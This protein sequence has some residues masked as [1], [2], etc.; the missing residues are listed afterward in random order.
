MLPSKL[1]LDKENSFWACVRW[2]EIDRLTTKKRDVVPSIDEI[3]KCI[4]DISELNGS[5]EQI[6]ICDE[7]QKYLIFRKDLLNNKIQYF[8]KMPKKQRKCSN[9]VN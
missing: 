2:I 9:I 3:K 4:S 7:V 8:F 6:N 1:F 5:A